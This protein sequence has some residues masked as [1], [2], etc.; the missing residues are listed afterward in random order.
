MRDREKKTI[1]FPGYTFL[2][3]DASGCLQAKGDV[4]NYNA[5]VQHV[6]GSVLFR[7]TGRDTASV[8]ELTFFHSIEWN[9]KKSEFNL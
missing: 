1:F 4:D 3:R 2:I 9:E 7:I 6:N 5:K 8:N